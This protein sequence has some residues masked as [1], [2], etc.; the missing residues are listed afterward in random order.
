V[1]GEAQRRGPRAIPIER[2]CQRCGQWARIGSL[3]CADCY[4][5]HLSARERQ[6]AALVAQGA[7]S[8]EIGQALG[9]AEATVPQYLKRIY[10]RLEID[11]SHKR[12]QLALWW[13][14]QQQ[15]PTTST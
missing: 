11:G 13:S 2:I 6:C 7:T 5:K 1:K 8:R 4:R 9:L 12:M 10:R 15:C 14:K 3:Y